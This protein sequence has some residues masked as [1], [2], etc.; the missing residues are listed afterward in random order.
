M[1]LI[2][3]NIDKVVL[4]VLYFVTSSAGVDG[5]VL[6]PLPVPY[7]PVRHC[8]PGVLQVPTSDARL[9]AKVTQLCLLC[10]LI[11]VERRPS[12]CYGIKRGNGV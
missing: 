10:L 5:R 9:P 8:P 3:H 12:A 11:L 6:V 7:P 1:R 4:F 2:D